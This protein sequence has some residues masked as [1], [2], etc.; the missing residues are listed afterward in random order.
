MAAA[1]KTVA[2]MNEWPA[3]KGVEYHNWHH[4]A[5]ISFGAIKN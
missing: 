5:V 3:K 1:N 4:R 2:D